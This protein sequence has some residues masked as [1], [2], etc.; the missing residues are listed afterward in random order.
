M[1]I[2]GCFKD[3]ITYNGAKLRIDNNPAVNVTTPTKCQRECQ[4]QINCKLWIWKGADVANKKMRDSCL[5]KSKRGRIKHKVHKSRGKVVS[6]PKYCPGIRV[7][8]V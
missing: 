5:L 6:G 8:S 1:T 3:N 7:D 4:K 2:D